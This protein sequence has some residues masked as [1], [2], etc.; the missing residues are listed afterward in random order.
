[1][2]KV[3]SVERQRD[4]VRVED[5]ESELADIFDFTRARAAQ[6]RRSTKLVA[7]SDPRFP[8]ITGELSDRLLAAL[9]DEIVPAIETTNG[10]PRPVEIDHE[11]IKKALVGLKASGLKAIARNNGLRVTQTVEQL[12]ETIARH[13][14]WNEEEIARLVL[15]NSEEIKPENGFS[16]RLFPLDG[17][18]D[19]DYVRERLT[20][21]EGR[22]I[23][24]GIAKWFV[25]DQIE[26]KGDSFELEGS[27]MSYSASIDNRVV[28]Q[29]RLSPV[30]S[31][32]LARVTADDT[33]LL[34]VTNATLTVARGAANAFE[35]ATRVAPLGRIPFID[36]NAPAVKGELHS[37]SLFM[38]D[39]LVNRLPAL[40]L[41]EI[42]MTVARFRVKDVVEPA[43]DDEEEP[44][45]A[46]RAVRFE[47]SYLLGNVQACRLLAV[48]QRPLSDVTIQVRTRSKDRIIT[49]RFPVRIAIEA[50]HV[51]IDTGYGSGVHE[52]SAQV[53]ANVVQAVLDEIE[54]GFGNES[55]L[56]DFIQKINLR[57]QADEGDDALDL[58]VDEA[59][60]I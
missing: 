49:G 7:T 51:A 14:G 6:I 59:D 1:M 52:L 18:P 20:Y 10:R 53:H 19:L 48:D 23:R 16:M 45:S 24:T 46:L 25:F 30:P 33:D 9:E 11:V 57:A 8:D 28:D 32:S 42:N 40:G 29:P 22:Y 34:R 60:Q 37:A 5:L 2:A 50:D 4:I 36:P 54:D 56:D 35:T 13:Y 17:P 47:G 58:L 21:V 15:A 41:G 27:Y 12:A 44:R 3:N 55:R 31:R 43:W 26:D 39:L 38:L